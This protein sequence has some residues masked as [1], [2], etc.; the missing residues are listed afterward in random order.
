MNISIGFS[1]DLNFESC[2]Y[3]IIE[4]NW[5]IWSVRFPISR[6]GQALL[7]LAI[8]GGLATARCSRGGDFHLQRRP[9]QWRFFMSQ[10]CCLKLG[11]RKKKVVD[12]HNYI[13]LGGTP[14]MMIKKATCAKIYTVISMANRRNGMK[15]QGADKTMRTTSQ[16]PGCM[17]RWRR[18]IIS[19]CGL[20]MLPNQS[21][22]VA[23]RAVNEGSS[24]FNSMNYWVMEIKKSSKLGTAAA[25]LGS[26]SPCSRPRPFSGI[27]RWFGLVSVHKWTG[28]AIYWSMPFV[29]RGWCRSTTSTGSM[30]SFSKSIGGQAGN[31]WVGRIIWNLFFQSKN[32][33]H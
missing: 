31:P 11:N 14:T 3:L 28:S 15:W 10:N 19:R 24:K 9:G 1:I 21:I 25:P 6:C 27:A 33:V 20:Q 23:S 22:A 17:A 4:Y 30:E 13:V 2:W 8:F 16:A 12:H 18:K 29:T 32:V 26:C 7:V 5:S